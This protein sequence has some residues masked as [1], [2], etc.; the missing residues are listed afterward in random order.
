[1]INLIDTKEKLAALWKRT[2]TNDKLDS[3]PTVLHTHQ[4][5]LREIGFGGSDVM[6]FL[7]VAN[8]VKRLQLQ[9]RSP[10]KNNNASIE[11]GQRLK[12]VTR[13]K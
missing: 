9:D 6:A 5:A 7:E 3:N 12:Q 10:S 1:M 13:Q 4:M 2:H 8:A 11:R